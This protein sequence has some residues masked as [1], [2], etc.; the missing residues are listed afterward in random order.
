V[1]IGI[2]L[3]SAYSVEAGLLESHA[4]DEICRLFSD[5]GLSCTHELLGQSGTDG[6]LLVMTGLEEFRQ[7][8]G[9]QLTVTMLEALGSGVEVH[10]ISETLLQRSVDR[11]LQWR[12]AA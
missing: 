1:A 9:G 7:H 12:D 10:E 2:A 6:R 5:I 11:L 4:F 8:L 3:D